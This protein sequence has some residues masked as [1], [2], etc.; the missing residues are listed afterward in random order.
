MFAT[1]IQAAMGLS[2]ACLAAWLGLA[3]LL[4]ATSAAALPVPLAGH[5]RVQGDGPPV[6]LQLAADRRLSIVVVGEAG[7]THWSPQVV[8]PNVVMG[9][10]DDGRVWSVGLSFGRMMMSLGTELV[11]LSPIGAEEFAA[12][13][14]EA[15][16]LAATQAATPRAPEA[17]AGLGGLA[18][19][20]A[21]S[22]GGYFEGRDYVFCSDGSFRYTKS[23]ST[24]GG[25]GER[26]YSGRW[27]LQGGQLRLAYSD[28]N[29]GSL[30]LRCV[31]DDVFL[32]WTARASS[33][34]GHVNAA[35]DARHLNFERTPKMTQH[36]KLIAAIV[37]AAGALMAATAFGADG[38]DPR[39]S[40]LPCRDRHAAEV[41]HAAQHEGVPR[42]APGRLAHRATGAW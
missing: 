36:T 41:L 2:R 12:A 25:A 1:A 16:R 27:M 8:R 21:S 20:T 24:S 9:T 13:A 32:T 29:R 18:L 39:S 3:L 23:F 34:S 37:F 15:A 33:P 10:L 26:K 6:L 40:Q 35:D 22:S 5:Y 17:A 7:R 28:G 42:N 31:A 19:S 30:P 11:N 38:A 14:S 4:A